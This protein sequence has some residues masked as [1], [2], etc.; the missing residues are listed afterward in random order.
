LLVHLWEPEAIESDGPVA[1]GQLFL[2]QKNGIRYE[3]LLGSPEIIEKTGNILHEITGLVTTIN[4]TE[5]YTSHP[6]SHKVLSSR[7]F[8]LKEEN[9]YLKG[10]PLGSIE[11][12]GSLSSLKLSY[13]K[14]DTQY[15]GS[16]HR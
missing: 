1:T 3:L 16:I 10:I 8:K 11:K 6:N 15:S 7:Q 4:R 2:S 12:T 14:I 9:Y 5:G 13:D